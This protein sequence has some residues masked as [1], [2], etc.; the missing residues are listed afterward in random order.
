M[1]DD[2]Y[3]RLSSELKQLVDARWSLVENLGIGAGLTDPAPTKDIALA[4]WSRFALGEF[5]VE[6]VDMSVYAHRASSARISNVEWESDDGTQKVN[7][8][9]FLTS[10]AK[11][12]A[13]AG[14][15]DFAFTFAGASTSLFADGLLGTSSVIINGSATIVNN[16]LQVDLSYQHAFGVELNNQIN[17]HVAGYKLFPLP[18]DETFAPVNYVTGHVDYEMSVP[19]WPARAFTSVETEELEGKILDQYTRNNDDKDII[20]YYAENNGVY[21]SAENP[22]LFPPKPSVPYD[23]IEID[24]KIL[25]LLENAGVSDLFENY[26][27]ETSDGR[28][29]LIFG[30]EE[31]IVLPGDGNPLIPIRE[32]LE[33]IKSGISNFGE[34]L[35][36]S[37][38][39]VPEIIQSLAPH[40]I[41][42]LINGDDLEAVAE[43]YAIQAGVNLGADFIINQFGEY[44][45]PGVGA[46]FFEGGAGGALKGAILQFAVT[47]ALAGGDLEGSDYAKLALNTSVQS[48]VKYAITSQVNLPNP[49]LNLIPASKLDVFSNAPGLTTPPVPGVA[50]ALAAAVTFVSNLFEKGFDDFGET[51]AQTT[52][53][54]ATAAVGSAISLALWN[55]A[56]PGFGFLI[57]G[58]ASAVLGDVMNRIMGTNMP[59]PPPLFAIEDNPDG[60]QT[61]IIS[62]VSGGY[63][64][65]ARDGFNDILI[66]YTGHDALVGSTGHNQ[67]TGR[68][69]DDNLFGHAGSDTISGGDGN[70]FAVGGIGDDQV[71]GGEGNDTLFGDYELDEGP[72]LPT[73]AEHS[74]GGS[75]T[76]FGG[77]GDDS[78]HGGAGDDLIGGDE[79]NDTLHG[80]EGHDAVLGGDGADLIYG[81]LG[82]D[83]LVGEAGNDSLFGEDGN[84]RLIGGEGDDSLSGD[85]GLDTLNGDEGQD[86]LEGGD[87]D[88]ALYGDAGNDTLFGQAGSDYLD[89]GAGDDVLTDDDGNDLLQGGE[90]NDLIT[91][92]AGD[93]RIY[94]D[95]ATVDPTTGDVTYSGTGADTID[96]GAGADVV[97][98]GSGNDFVDAGDGD[99]IVFG[100]DGDDML[101]GGAGDDALGGGAGADQLSGRDGDDALEGGD[102]TDYLMGDAGLDTLIGGE[103][104]DTL[105]GGTGVDSL[106]GDAGNDSLSA[107]DGDDVLAGGDGDDWLNGEAGADS[108]LGGA[109]NDRLFTGPGADTLEGGTGD[110]VYEVDL[111][112][113]ASIIRETDGNDRIEITG[114]YLAKNILLEKD[115]DDLIISD[116]ANAANFVRVVGQFA[117]DGQ[118][119]ELITFSDGFTINISNLII[120]DDGDN[121]IVGTE[122]DDAILGLGGNDTIMGEGGDD[123]IDGGDGEDII[124][125]GAG[126]DVVHGSGADDL[127]SGDAGDDTLI[128]GKGNDYLIGGSGADGFFITQ[129]ENDQDTI[130][131]LEKGVDTIDLSDF[132][133]T[134]VTVKQMKIF[135]DRIQQSGTDMTIA[136]AAG[137]LLTVDDVTAADFTDADFLFDLTDISGVAGTAENDR[138]TG[139]ATAD[140]IVDGAG[141]DVITSGAGADNIAIT[142]NMGDIDQI[143]DFDIAADV[144]DVRSFGDY[145]HIDQLVLSQVGDDTVLTFADTNQNV[146]LEGVDHTMLT[147]ANFRF[148]LF[149]DQISNVARFDASATHDFT[150]D[151]VIETDYSG[152]SL[153]AYAGQI[154]GWANVSYNQGASYSGST[155]ANVNYNTVDKSNPL[156]AFQV[157]VTFQRNDETV[158]EIQTHYQ[159]AEGTVYTYQPA[160]TIY[161]NAYYEQ[162]GGIFPGPEELIFDTHFFGVGHGQT[163]HGG[164][165]SEII[166]AYGGHDTVYGGNGLD[167]ID[168]GEGHDSLDG[169]N[170]NDAIYGQNGHDYL[171]G[172]EGFDHLRGGAGNDLVFGHTGNDLLEGGTGDDYL[173]GGDG[174][175]SA[176]GNQGR[177][178]ITGGGG[179]DILLGNEGD[180]HIQGDDGD[181][182]LQGGSGNDQLHGGS[183]TDYIFGEAGNDLISGQGD[184]DNISGG[185]GNDLIHAGD[186]NDVAT[187][188]ADQDYI[189]GESG[190]DQLSG[191]AGHDILDGGTGIDNLSGDD[192]N[193]TLLGGDGNDVLSGG[194]GNDHLQ[195]GSGDDVATGGAGNDYIIGNSDGNWIHGGS[196]VDVITGGDSGEIIY[197]GSGSDL[198]DGGAGSDL[199]YGG[200]NSDLLRGGADHDRLIGDHGNDTLEG[201]DGDDWLQGGIGD[202]SLVGGDGKDSLEGGDGDD[203]LIGGAQNDVLEGGD[204]NDTLDGGTGSD[205]MTG[206]LGDDTYVIDSRFDYI[207]AEAANEGTDTIRSHIAATTGAITLATHFENGEIATAAGGILNGNEVANKLTGGSGDDTLSGAMGADTIVGGLGNDVILGGDGDDILFG[208]NVI[209]VA[210]G[211]DLPDPTGIIEVDIANAS[212]D[213]VELGAGGL[214]MGIA[215]WVSVGTPNSSITW[216]PTGASLDTGPSEENIYASSTSGAISQTLS[217][218]F[219]SSATYTF[220][221]DH[222]TRLDF[223]G[224]QVTATIFAGGGI[225]G[226]VVSPIPAAGTWQSKTIVID[227]ASF[228]GYEG[229]PMEI[230]LASTGASAGQ[231]ALNNLSLTKVYEEGVEA[232]TTVNVDIANSSFDEIVMGDGGLQTTIAGWTMSSA[233]NTAITWNPTEASLVTGDRTENILALSTNGALHQTLTETLDA[234]ARYFF[235]FD[236]GTRSDFTGSEVT[237]H[238]AVN[239]VVIGQ[240]V[241]AAP[242]LGVWKTST[243]IVDGADFAGYAGQAVTIQLVGTGSIAGQA[244]I[245]NVRLIKEYEPGIVVVDGPEDPIG[246]GVL[247]DDLSE[248]NG[249]ADNLD[250]GNGNDQIA[251]GSG[252]DTLAGGTGEDS[253]HGGTGDD[254]LA[255][256]DGNDLIIGGSGADNLAGGTG[257]DLFR[258]EALEESSISA[259]DIIVDFDRVMDKVDLSLIATGFDDLTVT[260]TGGLTEVEIDG[261]DFL[262]QI[263]GTGHNLSA[264]QFVFPS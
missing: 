195:T 29:I 165:W 241:S 17:T 32:F 39:S 153:D 150:A 252:N 120:G 46:Q 26:V 116:R 230:R 244:A 137:Q 73:T 23:E 259:T 144:L 158:T 33:I 222:G 123:F 242:Q 238:I 141:F 100:M 3:S 159:D 166:N 5:A 243:I 249:G 60:S 262:L 8:A 54:G 140:Q 179:N 245:N 65:Q 261:T 143:T 178:F 19:Y 127:L 134:F 163:M 18:G 200:T 197:G 74:I 154:A 45:D 129:N 101:D 37:I 113:A 228:T 114:G 69:G 194:T 214:R 212:F 237:A 204:G 30:N 211:D 264:D 31:E 98:A 2:P 207:V 133:G 94:G 24:V 240:T 84:D 164:Y 105:E 40:I 184:G 115:G 263:D 147:A 15:T 121:N 28:K 9:R 226:Q 142:Q 36:D 220:N 221:F 41:A 168:G 174:A 167:T 103:G 12:A 61:V 183:G 11:V 67:L 124:Y 148:D 136:L 232:R 38:S 58:V 13:D 233:L 145:I 172:R 7:F 49:P 246:P 223:P 234:S 42:D 187:G 258:Y 91:A 126:S 109:G 76:I 181:D 189:L 251:G 88:D 170:G 82:N 201:D 77:E 219:D 97:F 190:H 57:G 102:G 66:G 196:G 81:Q 122:E 138:I 199:V 10:K 216:N 239:G 85:A 260:E 139:T 254:Q 149:E 209:L 50:A 47:A 111:D 112:G 173:N 231:A 182:N 218:S 93:N 185:T 176:H 95:I 217:E 215:H 161:N 206:G 160:A 106:Q 256:D 35:E 55:V 210:D 107:G 59:P 119:V 108:V 51:I 132:G 151:S 202:D 25:D 169:G 208:D 53:A 20:R 117:T 43:R 92:G 247:T 21:P 248:V 68:A 225:V 177:D 135:G 152:S 52:V 27:A 205:L 110:D 96:A 44:I 250:G 253:L 80:G 62:D 131:D 193:D 22:P 125:G 78:V 72:G 257:A 180:D 236:H 56:F 63:A 171:S 4:Q 86:L 203:A 162:T 89:G 83:E 255:G 229:M 192:G 130:A 1:S 75:D 186:G 79:G 34:A 224:S 188:G 64:Y 87:G 213:E 235:H 227:G 14:E 99:D 156:T 90:G 128:S 48:L 104:D 155:Y 70:D 16:E 6:T 175:D 157:S 191:G 146:L 71:F 198:I 118:M